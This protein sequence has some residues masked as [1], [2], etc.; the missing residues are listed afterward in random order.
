[1][2][3]SSGALLLLAAL[4]LA[5]CGDPAPLPPQHWLERLEGRDEAKREE[6]VL[7]LG[8]MGRDDVPGVRDLL[9]ARLEERG[10]GALLGV[11]LEPDVPGATPEERQRLVAAM[12][13]GVRERLRLAG[14]VVS[15]LT[16]ENGALELL[17]LPPGE[18]ADPDAAQALLVREASRPLAMALLP[19]LPPPFV[20]TAERPTS[21]WPGDAASYEAWHKEER[22]RLE[23]AQRERRPYEPA[24]PTRRLLPSAIDGGGAAEE[25]APVRVPPEAAAQFRED[26]LLFEPGDD[27]GHPALAVRAVEARAADF[28]AFLRSCAG[29]R[30]WLSVDGE[31]LFASRLPVEPGERVVF[32]VRATSMAQGRLWSAQVAALAA[33]GRFPAPVKA[34]AL[35]RAPGL[36]P[37]DPLCRAI[38][39]AGPPMEPMLDALVARDG[40]W[41]DLVEALKNG[42]LKGRAVGTR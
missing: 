40:S 33:I 8:R 24:E 20:P 37:T 18:V 11:R 17:A 9:M 12:L 29:L 6:A 28:R 3:G 39:E 4:G 30:L 25:P 42:I 1:M 34:R 14:R 19:E 21:P 2:R 38:V 35:P 26:E 31:G 32:R 5:G 7:Q 41:R 15:R 16:S 36:A 27:E 10:R 23:A 22:A 13:P